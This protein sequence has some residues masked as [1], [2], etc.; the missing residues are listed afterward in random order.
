MQKGTVMQQQRLAETQLVH[1]V[2]EQSTTEATKFSANPE[3]YITH[4]LYEG[5]T[6]AGMTDMIRNKEIGTDRTSL[7]AQLSGQ[8]TLNA[9]S[10]I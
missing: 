3:G 8:L 7:N 10:D 6:L 4:S 2:P 9:C 5:R 1:G